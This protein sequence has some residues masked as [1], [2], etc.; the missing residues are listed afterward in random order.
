MDKEIQD[1]KDKLEAL[2]KAKNKAKSNFTK[3]VP[4]LFGQPGE[5]EGIRQ[6]Y[7]P[8]KFQYEFKKFIEFLK[9]HH[10]EKGNNFE[11]LKAALRMKFSDNLQI[12]TDGKGLGVPSFFELSTSIPPDLKPENFIKIG[13]W[14]VQPW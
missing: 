10:K 3:T 2:I 7:K 6:T 4:A 14:Y 9:N 8:K 5:Y 1:L 11:D 13:N 12:A